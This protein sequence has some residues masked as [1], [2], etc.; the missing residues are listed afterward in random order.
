VG[1]DMQADR[2]KRDNCISGDGIEDFYGNQHSLFYFDFHAEQVKQVE[3]VKR[4]YFV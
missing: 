3:R 4:F 1:V 2:H